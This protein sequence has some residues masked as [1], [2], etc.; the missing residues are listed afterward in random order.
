ML[1]GTE[2]HA[3]CIHSYVGFDIEFEIPDVRY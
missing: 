2:L 3:Y 1:G